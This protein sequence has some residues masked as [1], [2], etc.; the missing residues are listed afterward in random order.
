MSR[1]IYPA[2]LPFLTS[3]TK[4][5]YT[6]VKKY[7]SPIISY[8]A[9]YVYTYRIFI[10]T[11]QLRGK[12][13][14]L[15]IYQILSVHS[16]KAILM[17]VRVCSQACPSVVVR[18]RSKSTLHTCWEFVKTFTPQFCGRDSRKTEPS[19]CSRRSNKYSH[20]T[21]SDH[22]ARLDRICPQLAAVLIRD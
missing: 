3:P 2:L 7:D 13:F 12:S 5:G 14:R 8:K 19:K 6:I 15:M 11:Y 9:I 17:Y 4:K 16:P 21:N 18:V 22:R 20:S 1:P 10:R